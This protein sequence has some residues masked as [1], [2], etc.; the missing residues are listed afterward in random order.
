MIVLLSF[1]ASAVIALVAYAQSRSFVTRR[2]DFHFTFAAG[3][4]TLPIVMR[5]SSAIT[6]ASPIDSGMVA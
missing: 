1:L 2:P 5:Q 6:S 3:T 4:T